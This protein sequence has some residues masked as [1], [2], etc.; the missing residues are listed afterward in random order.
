MKQLLLACLVMY[1]SVNG[2]AQKKR[3]P[4]ISTVPEPPH[5]SA[6]DNGLSGTLWQL[7]VDTSG[8][9]TILKFHRMTK[10]TIAIVQVHFIDAG[11]FQ[12]SVHTKGSTIRSDG[13]Y[14]IYPSE[15][16][17]EEGMV[18]LAPPSYL[19]FNKYNNQA[20]S[21][22]GLKRKIGNSYSV[23]RFETNEFTL[24]ELPAPIA[25]AGGG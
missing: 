10:T 18:T 4:Q 12:L 2:Y 9:R 24:E 5:V 22:E 19:S 21:I 1:L 15:T 13:S 8:K 11:R 3:A 6:K 16:G 20:P 23:T 17:Y 7:V 25:P 14:E